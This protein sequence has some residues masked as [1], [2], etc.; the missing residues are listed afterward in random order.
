MPLRQGCGGRFEGQRAYKKTG[1]GR[2]AQGLHPCS[3]VRGARARLLKWRA[4]LS[5]R[6]PWT[7]DQ[8][9]RL[10]GRSL[11]LWGSLQNGGAPDRIRTCDLWNRNPTLYPAELRVHAEG[12][13]NRLSDGWFLA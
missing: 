12:G 8:V 9:K 11:W 7:L 3:R 10:R 1:A 6:R 13:L 2:I 4:E 5:P